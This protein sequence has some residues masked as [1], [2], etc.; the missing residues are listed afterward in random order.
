MKNKD[1]ITEF[2]E[3]RAWLFNLIGSIAKTYPTDSDQELVLR[4]A[5]HALLFCGTKREEFLAFLQ[6]FPLTEREKR[7]IKR[8]GFKL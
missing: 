2:L 1:H 7:F 3:K 4:L 8:S 5:A 6:S